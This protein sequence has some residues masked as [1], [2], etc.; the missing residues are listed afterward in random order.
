MYICTVMI[1]PGSMSA[2]S[3]SLLQT[4]ASLSASAPTTRTQE[5]NSHEILVIL[6]CVPDQADSEEYLD[7]TFK[8]F[9]RYFG[10]SSDVSRKSDSSQ[11]Q[12]DD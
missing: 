9:S 5:A 6:P 11:S 7:R 12:T 3:S 10:F 1:R 2:A 4:D 8:L